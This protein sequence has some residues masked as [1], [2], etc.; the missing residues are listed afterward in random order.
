MDNDITLVAIDSSPTDQLSTRRCSPIIDPNNSC[1]FIKGFLTITLDA[2]FDLSFVETVLVNKIKTILVELPQTGIVPG[3]VHASFY[4][5]F[6]KDALKPNDSQESLA[7]NIDS[8]QKQLRDMLSYAAIVLLC[9][10]LAAFAICALQYRNSTSKAKSADAEEDQDQ[11]PPNTPPSPESFDSRPSRKS[12]SYRSTYSKVNLNKR[13]SNIWE[14]LDNNREENLSTILEGSQEDVASSCASSVFGNFPML[15]PVQDES[16]RDIELIDLALSTR[17]ENDLRK[18]NYSE[19]Q[20]KD[21]QNFRAQLM[22]TAK[23]KSAYHSPSLSSLEEEPIQL[24]SPQASPR[25]L[26][27]RIAFN[28]SLPISIHRMKKASKKSFEYT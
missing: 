20:I 13:L 18:E 3:L 26:Q 16:E 10:T 24:P 15:S 1:Q 22:H 17:E 21:L 27:D 5:P 8:K 23:T 11:T 7:N 4:D 28:R 12:R 2:N 25:R 14:N 6:S 19:D 9:F